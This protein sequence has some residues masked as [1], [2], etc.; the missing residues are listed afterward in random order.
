MPN[1]IGTGSHTVHSNMFNSGTFTWNGG[2]TAKL[3]TDKGTLTFT[4]V[5]KNAEGCLVATKGSGDFAGWWGNLVDQDGDGYVLKIGTQK[6][7][8]TFDIQTDLAKG[9]IVN[10]SIH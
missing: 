9:K 1:M 4:D 2:S 3:V 5:H 8:G 10:G 7:D 6:P